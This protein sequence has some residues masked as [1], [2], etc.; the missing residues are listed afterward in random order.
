MRLL[1]VGI[2]SGR[3]HNRLFSLP[4]IPPASLFRRGHQ[5]RKTGAARGAPTSHRRRGQAPVGNGA[6]PRIAVR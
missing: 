6:S 3:L 4:P 2:W 1:R 5:I